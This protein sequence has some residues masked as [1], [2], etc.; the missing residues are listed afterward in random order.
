MTSTN[1]QIK[2]CVHKKFP[3]GKYMNKYELRKRFWLYHF[4]IYAYQYYLDPCDKISCA[5]TNS[6]CE[7]IYATGYPTC[8]CPAG[9]QG[10]PRVGI[11]CG[12]HSLIAEQY[13]RNFM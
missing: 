11:A 2:G 13:Y 10:D 4:P 9:M 12:M 7:V 1:A 5:D 6:V 8:V 3:I